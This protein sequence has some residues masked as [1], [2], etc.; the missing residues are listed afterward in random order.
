ML[1]NR[2]GRRP[3]AGDHPRP[4]GYRTKRQLASPVDHAGDR[5][6]PASS[7]GSRDVSTMDVQ[8]P[9]A[10]TTSHVFSGVVRRRWR[11][12]VACSLLAVLLAAAYHQLRPPRFVSTASVLVAPIEAGDSAQPLNG[13]R[14]RGPLDLAT[15]AQLVRST[16]VAAAARSALGGSR[17]ITELT[18]AVSTNVPE[19]SSIIQISF[20]AGTAGEAQR[21]AEAFAAAYLAHRERTA[22]SNLDEQIAS[23]QRQIVKVREDLA[24]ASAAV[25]TA[26]PRS[27]EAALAHTS[28]DLLTSQL[29]TL[30]RTLGALQA[31]PTT[32]GRVI[33]SASGTAAPSGPPLPVLLAGG[34][35]LGLLLGSS[36]ALLRERTDRR[37][38]TAADVGHLAGMPVVPLTDG[39]N[40]RPLALVEP[41]SSTDGQSFRRLR[42]T[43]LSTLPTGG[44]LILVAGA[45]QGYAT[46]RV[47][48]N[49]A[50]ALARSDCSVVFV[51]AYAEGAGDRGRPAEPSP[52]LSE[53]LA[54]AC[55]LRDA[56]RPVETV[57][58]L[59][60]IGAG[61]D[62]DGLTRQLQRRAAGSVMGGLKES[63]DF[64]VV[65]TAPATTSPDA[66]T[67]ARWADAGIV[68][69]EAGRTLGTQLT[70]SVSQFHEV[71]L[72]RLWCV[73]ARQQPRPGPQETGAEEAML[74]DP[75]PDG[76]GVGPL[77]LLVPPDGAPGAAPLDRS[78]AIPQ[79]RRADTGP[80]RPA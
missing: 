6:P 27:P 51:D 36:V 54:G 14:Q 40:L 2:T 24:A 34:A 48:V 30:S 15:E 75:T 38:R 41:Y 23:L 25:A 80:A 68:V 47:G 62:C 18:A 71:G 44:R 65:H 64:V 77:P 49:L 9:A 70:N 20:E 26:V 63:C 57:P 12:L 67:V 74:G 37:V 42:N 11:L 21:G 43:L 78:M 32:P 19:E 55:R 60:W 33:T 61:R 3:G 66:Q 22:R 4:A 72:T 39:G 79:A 46:R 8:V 28:A 76:H 7:H 50:A 73:L 31:S 52:G 45:D 17:S 56:V 29:S 59:W 1:G 69:V 5:I 10:A 35:L 58:N 13:Q 16:A 53:M